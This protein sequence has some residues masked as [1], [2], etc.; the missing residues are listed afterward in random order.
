[1]ST[2]FFFF[3]S[4]APT[5]WPPNTLPP[6]RFDRKTF[7]KDHDSA[8]CP[9]EKKAG[10][11]QLR[12]KF[13]FI[14][15]GLPCRLLT[16]TSTR[17]HT[18]MAFAPAVPRFVP[19]KVKEHNESQKLRTK[20]TWNRSVWLIVECKLR[21]SR[22]PLRKASHSHSCSFEHCFLHHQRLNHW[23]LSVWMWSQSSM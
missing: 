19:M 1:M 10:K 14:V 22:A 6:I 12:H 13:S 2:R 9:V 4:G 8:G 20:C 16:P 5:S 15:F 7:C 11:D 21:I 17:Y 23:T 3:I 18:S